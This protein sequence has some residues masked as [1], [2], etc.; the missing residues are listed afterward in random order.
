MSTERSELVSLSEG[1]ALRLARFR[2]PGSQRPVDASMLGVFLRYLRT[3]PPPADIHKFLELF[4]ASSW[5]RFTGS[6]GPQ[7][8]FLCSQ[9]VQVMPRLHEPELAEE[10]AWVLGT[11]QRLM[12]V[13]NPDRGRGGPGE[14]RGGRGGHRGRGGPPGGRGRR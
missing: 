5:A 10:L 6:S 3:S 13:H 1:L 11:A 4:P 2:S 7:A 14:G 9:V 8:K 12:K